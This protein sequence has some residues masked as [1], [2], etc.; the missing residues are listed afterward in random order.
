[1]GS[2]RRLPVS[3]QAKRNSVSAVILMIVV[4]IIGAFGARGLQTK[5]SIT[6]FSPEYNPVTD[7]D[8]R[9]RAYFHLKSSPTFVGLIALRP[10]Q[11]G[12][13][14]TKSRMNRLSILTKKIEILAGV[15][16]V[17]SLANVNAVSEKRGILGVGP[18]IKVTPRQRWR[19]RIAGDELL[20]PTLIS[21]DFR[22]ILVYAQLKN[23][24]VHLLYNFNSEFKQKLMHAFS[25]AQVSVGGVP[26]VQMELGVLLNKELRNFLL[27]TVLACA[28]TLFLI[29]RTIS[30][31][32]IPLI[33][34]AFGNVL[35]F[36]MMAWTKQPFTILSAT[37][38]IL[39]FI[40]VVSLSVHFLLRFVEDV[41]KSEASTPRWDVILKVN[42]EIWLPNLLGAL[43]TCIGFLTLLWVDVPLIRSYGVEVA[44]AVMISWL[45]T[46]FGILPLLMLFPHPVPR[47]WVTRKVKWPLWI[48][49]RAKP[50][51]AFIVTLCVV[52]IMTAH[53][54]YWTAR[55]FNDIPKGEPARVS[56][57]KIAQ[58]VGGVIPL[59]IA[60]KSNVKSAWSDPAKLKKLKALLAKLRDTNGVGAAL[61]VPN[62]FYELAEISKPILPISRAAVSEIYFLYSMSDH[63]PLDRYLSSNKRIVRIALRIRDL[64]S[65][66][67]KA[68]VQK[69]KRQVQNYFPHDRVGTGGTGAT[70]HVI[71]DYISSELIGGFWQAL[72][73]IAI[74]LVI[75]FRSI[76]TM[77][78]VML[79]NL[80]PPIFL[81]GY[82]SL[83]HTPIKPGV[84]V[85]F[86]IALGL[87]FNNTVYL[88]NRLRAFKESKG[89]VRSSQVTQAFC[90]ESKPCLIS[91]A[92]F[93]IGFS[94]F[95]FSY[96]S[97]NRTFGLCMIVSL[98]GGAIGDLIFLPA[99]LACRKKII[100]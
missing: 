32:F 57:E 74:T 70:V 71:Q 67:A 52:L 45:A 84:A 36:A 96:F 39:I 56:T 61:S 44:S 53:H 17:L 33:F 2:Q 7:M 98:T 92:I 91:T 13:W 23:D 94:V 88:L 78:I 48:V 16:R 21:K 60:V 83:T 99:V 73:I 5:Y 97:L 19:Q 95:L 76:R 89:I 50:I 62:F 65:N 37:I 93:L 58:A 40:T 11:K 54:L 34:T 75:I 42:K 82:L 51:A 27:L 15:K 100:L 49:Q 26:A 14:L 80:M 1:M 3:A 6:Q 85:I 41:K 4:I 10:N 31:M 55:L 64:P 38:P 90:L 9:V 30:T 20:D 25:R 87:A 79:P 69:L 24:D 29:F 68:L 46:S 72:L 18:L 35:A 22:T 28:I 59:D 63:D 12:T 66:A 43:T 47:R 86:S 81:L 8:R 77:L